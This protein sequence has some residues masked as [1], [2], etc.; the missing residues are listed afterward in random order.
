VQGTHIVFD[1]EKFPTEHAFLIPETE[2]GRV[3]FILPW[4]DHLI[5]GTTDIKKE[6]PSLD[7]R[8]DKSEIDIILETFN[9]YAK[10]KA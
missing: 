7:P 9:Q 2:D 4:Q 10:D 6:V 5:V 8:A 3:L 1:R